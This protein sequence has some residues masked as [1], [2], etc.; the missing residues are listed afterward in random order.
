MSIYGILNTGRT[1]MTAHSYATGVTAQ[2]AENATTA[3][4][5][6]RLARLENVAP[7]QGGVR[8]RGAR[9]VVD[10]FINKR[11]LGAGSGAGYGEAKASALGVLDHV[12]ADGPGDLGERIGAFEAGLVELSTHPSEGGTRASVL[13]RA[14]ALADA[15]NGAAAELRGAR[16]EI[17][18]RIVGEVDAINASAARIADLGSQ[19][20]RAEI[21]GQE[22]SDLRDLRDQELRSLAERA[23][24]TVIE[25]EHG[26]MNVLLAG[27]VSL[28][29]ED[30][31]AHALRAPIDPGSGDVVI[32]RQEVGVDRDV[33]SLFTSGSVGGMIDARDGA[34]NDA[35]SA[36]DQLA[37]D[38]AGAYNTAHQAGVGLD[39]VGGR[40]LFD[41]GVVDGAA[42]RFG[43]S[44]DVAGLPDNIAAATDPLAVDGDNRGALA[45]VDLASDPFARG[46]TETA[47]GGYAR[48]VADAGAGVRAALDGADTAAAA[49]SQV[50]ALR[51][52][53]S[54]VS[55]DDEMV[56]LMELQR[57]YQATLK[58]IQTAD[59][60]LESLI[61][62]KR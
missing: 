21:G 6:R 55:T 25:G 33:S 34:L 26:S 18:D 10:P 19:I 24:I 7:P 54:G 57:G 47:V 56:T 30:H 32:T 11:L 41:A 28:V 4:Y 62:L 39:G 50:S 29:D 27:S 8:A 42:A 13:A 14:E 37:F 22:A 16:S 61:N 45:L 59:E 1:G 23:P 15:F 40:D 60:M 36:L 43:V 17:N 3:G 52:G 46:G 2:N 31:R 35:E 58:V 49:L 48:I 5:S 9:R 44:A 51:E 53:I 20:T 12:F 38:F